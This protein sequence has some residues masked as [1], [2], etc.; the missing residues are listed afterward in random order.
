MRVADIAALKEAFDRQAVVCGEMGAPFTAR[1]NRVLGERLDD[2]TALGRRVVG[3]PQATLRGDLVPLRCCAAL[4][5]KV[6]GGV[7]PA[8]ARLYPP[9]AAAS[10]AAL[11]DAIADTIARHDA[12]LA[13]FLDS[14]PQTNEV[15]RSGVL[16]AG[17]LSIAAATGMPLALFELGASA[18]LNLMFDRYA[19]DLGEGRTWGPAAA[20][21]RIPCVWTGDAPSLATPIDVVSRAAVDL[22]PI[23][24]SDAQDRERLLAYIWP[25]Q[26]ERVQ[27]IEA[28]LG[29]LA[30]EHVTVEADDAVAW[31]K[32]RLAEPQAERT[33]RVVYHSVFLQYLPQEARQA[34]RA[35]LESAGAAAT[36]ARPFAWLAMEAAPDTPM[37]CQLTLRVWPSGERRVLAQV[38]WHGKWARFPASS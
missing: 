31:A 32:R 20:D 33:C 19:F 37:T 4:N 14:P 3:W 36:N 16:L 8:L 38:D 35:V 13:A 11:W 30:A 27:R 15:A 18:G 29:M 21:V 24:A 6:R 2:T 9:H 12:S 1:L 28:A 22:R 17:F 7:A 25:E 5:F 10:D 34:L 23:S 26:T